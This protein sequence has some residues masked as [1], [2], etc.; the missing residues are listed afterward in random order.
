[1]VAQGSIDEIYAKLDLQRIV[2]AQITNS[3]GILLSRIEA[4]RGV[5]KVEV[6]VDR[7]AIHVREEEIAVEDLLRKI[8]SL[9]GNVRMFQPQVMDMETAFM[10]LTEGKLS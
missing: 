7:I 9:G 6:E 2:H 5:T 3:S 8:L 10:R 1:M 4:R